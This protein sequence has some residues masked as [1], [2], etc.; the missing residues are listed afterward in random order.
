MAIFGAPVEEKDHAK[1]ACTAALGD[2][3][4]APRAGRGVGEDRPAAAE[5]A[6]RHQLGPDA[7]RQLRLQVPLQLR[8]ARRPGEPRVA[9]RGAG[10]GLRDRDHDRG[11]HR[12]ADRRRLPAARARQGA[13]QGA[14][15]GAAHLRAAG[16]A[17]RRAAAEPGADADALRGRAGR[18]TAT[19]AGTRRRRS[20]SKCL[21]L[22]PEDG[23]S[24]ADARAV[25]CDAATRRRPRTGTARTST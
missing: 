19:A 12:R 7:G 1:L 13:G 3:R 6:H 9:P 17:W 25:R 10:Q 8:R 22:W 15:A 2:A 18:S 16:R 14:Q 21:A 11:G 23:P 20:S 24:R 4:R 5:G